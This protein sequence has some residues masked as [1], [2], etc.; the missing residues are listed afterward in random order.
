MSEPLFNLK[1]MQG[2]DIIAFELDRQIQVNSDQQIHIQA[3]ESRI[4][5]LEDRIKTLVDS[6]SGTNNW[7]LLVSNVPPILGTSRG[8]CKPAL[9]LILKTLVFY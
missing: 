8:K 6:A 4:K 9:P 7:V 2:L 1:P 3:L 5:E